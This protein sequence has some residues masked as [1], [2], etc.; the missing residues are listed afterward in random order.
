MQIRAAAAVLPELSE[1][2]LSERLKDLMT[3]G[4]VAHRRARGGAGVYVLTSKGHSLGKL[5]RDLYEW[6]ETHAHVFHV[7]VGNPPA[8]LCERT[9]D[10]RAH[11]R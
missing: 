1:K 11:A 9:R 7:E 8:A 6:G 2:V 10:E 5:L 3:I 4:L